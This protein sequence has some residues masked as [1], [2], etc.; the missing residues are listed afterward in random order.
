MQAENASEWGKRER[1]ETEK[2]AM[3][4]DN[5]KLRAEIRDFQVYIIVFTIN[6]TRNIS[7]IKFKE[8]S[9]KK[10]RPIQA[11]DA[12]YRALQQELIERNKV[13]HCSN[14]NYNFLN[15]LNFYRK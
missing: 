11:S 15:I 5:K 9:D 6:L 14:I 10:G 7:N 12:E 2:L 4:R 8:R 13:I 1:L 3:E